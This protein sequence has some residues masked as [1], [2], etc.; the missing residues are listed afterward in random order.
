MTNI[1]KFNNGLAPARYL[2]KNNSMVGNLCWI[3][4]LKC[5]ERGRLK[6]TDYILFQNCHSTPLTPV[7]NWGKISD[8]AFQNTSREKSGSVT[9]KG[10][11]KSSES[12]KTCNAFGA[13]HFLKWI[14]QIV[15][16]KKK[17]LVSHFPGVQFSF[18]ILISHPQPTVWSD[19]AV[20]RQVEDK[21]D[22]STFSIV[23]QAI[24][25][26]FLL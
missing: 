15:G 21:L 24:N 1:P 19:T 2:V 6:R 5:S 4:S 10:P 7:L 23:T 14:K 13:V 11:K 12:K 20:V 3:Q 17:S 8:I 16:V 26:R 22:R 18:V 25:N 9:P